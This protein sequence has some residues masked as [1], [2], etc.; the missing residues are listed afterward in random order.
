MEEF[1]VY[2]R[3]AK[4][5]YRK[6]VLYMITLRQA[7]KTIDIR[8]NDVICIVTQMEGWKNIDGKRKWVNEISNLYT[9]NSLAKRFDYKA[10][11]VIKIMHYFCCGDC[12]GWKIWVTYKRQEI[13]LPKQ[14]HERVAQIEEEAGKYRCKLS[15]GW[16]HKGDR[17]DFIIADSKKE[18]FRELKNTIQK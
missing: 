1:V 4:K 12:D 7:I 17:F 3:Q 13:K 2:Y 11:R 14:Y 6:E 15:K 18:L 10:V 16:I 8:A 5:R 9:K